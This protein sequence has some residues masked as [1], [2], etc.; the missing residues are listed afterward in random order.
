[1]TD[2]LPSE[3]HFVSSTPGAPTCSHSGEYVGGTLICSLGTLNPGNSQTVTILVWPIKAGPIL[4]EANA[5]ANEPDR[6]PK[7][8]RATV[9][10]IIK[11]VKLADL[12]IDKSDSDDPV[13]LGQEFAYYLEVKNLGPNDASTVKIV[14][15]L[16]AGVAYVTYSA[17]AGVLCTEAAGVVTCTIPS[18]PSGG[19]VLIKLVV[20]AIAVGDWSNTATVGQESPPDPDLSNNTDTERTKI[21]DL[22]GK[23]A[24]VFRR[25]TFTANQFKTLLQGKGFT[26][27]LIQLPAVLGT[28]FNPYDLIIIAD[29]T[30]DLNQWPHG[31]TGASPE[32][33]H[34]DG[35]NKPVVGLGEGGYAYFGM[36]GAEIGW[37]HGWH[38]PLDRVKPDNVGAT[39]YHVPTDFGAPPPD[40][41]GLYAV[42]PSHVGIYLPSASNV[43]PFGLE[44][45]ATDHAPLIAERNDC[46]QL[47]GFSAGPP[48]MTTSGED[49]FVNTVVFGLGRQCAP[50]PDP[51]ECIEL[52]KEAT[53]PAGTPVQPGDI[54]AYR[55]KYS[56]KN[57]P[58]C[59]AERAEL[60]DPVPLDTIYV[61]NT[62]S[63]GI[64]PGAD[65]VLRWNLGALAPGASG[66]KKFEVYVKHT[67]CVNQ[68]TIN[69]RA[70]LVS[71]LG[72]FF[73][74][75]VSHP[76]ECP[77]VVPDDPSTPPY[78]E[79]EIQIY[80]YPLVAGHSTEIKVR[81]RSLI[82]VTQQVSVSLE[83][84]PQNFGIGI[85]FSTMT[86][87]NNPKVVTLPP[88]G[89]VEVIWNW[90][91]PKS[92]H[93]CIRVRI[94]SAGRE[95]IFT[96][97]NL[98]VT[99]NLQPGVPD[100]L[101]IPVRNPKST[102]E[103][104]LLVV[105]NTC[106]GWAATVDPAVLTNMTSGEIR[107]AKLTVI[108]PT[109]RPLGTAC[110]IDVQGWIG[111]E[112]IGGIRK[113][114]VPPVH[115]PPANPP[116]MEKEIS[117]IP[118]PPVV[119]QPAQICVEL[120]NPLASA[121]TVS[122]G[123]DVA[124]FGAG[125]SFT[126][127]A[128]QTVTLPPTSIDDYCIN[129]T[130]ASG[131]TL[132]RC[133][134][135]RLSQPG[136]GDQTSQRNV[137]LV[138]LPV[139]SIDELLKVEI[140]FGIG[141]PALFDRK[142]ELEAILVGLTPLVRPKIVP[143]P[144]P[145]IKPAEFLEFMLGFEMMNGAQAAAESA[146]DPLFYGDASRVE[147]TL[148]LDGEDS[149]GF[150]L[151]IAPPPETELYLPALNK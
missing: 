14:D 66:E 98:D 91:P 124:D 58:Q 133:I 95:P 40:P 88:F 103:N 115:L 33:S 100:E 87:P 106:P 1:M 73:S 45:A 78:A 139:L 81:I 142:L 126:E 31:T 122:I 86:I 10:T 105:D 64:S 16:P 67:S 93:F 32:A 102:T 138:R 148:M 147:V 74:N 118:D 75:V 56:V 9:R 52:S 136:S 65:G 89:V 135:I 140:P 120:Q 3:V 37:P 39:Y 36:L 60:Q 5:T 150:T 62:A 41:L 48:D 146:D 22:A 125:I 61:P 92:G 43:L 114:D 131:G 54:I 38:G 59:R 110:H 113:L 109:D 77:P 6:N 83:T 29:D 63:D 69:D 17:P 151:D 19:S 28:D 2:T 35:F 76:V 4:N 99:E 128:S 117:V 144:P 51:G 15:T 71:D 27:D 24:Y 50:P 79:D 20:R 145:E 112:L 82:S 137:N 46:N 30:G 49:L 121:R 8:N 57:T 90:T 84:S 26:V 108:P 85:D 23:I 47:W 143:D 18:I 7:D 96:Q 25:D 130:P 94:V 119:G 111:T 72:I 104:I 44:P 123:Y 101:P 68:R 97:R 116:W 127:V 141:N 70:R 34:I 53:P 149:G 42:T 11:T 80:P 21:V 13:T 55:V 129:W 107:N 12:S 132:H 134:R